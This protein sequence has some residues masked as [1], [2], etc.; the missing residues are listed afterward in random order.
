LR[1]AIIAPGSRGDV[2]P[3]LALGK[4]LTQAGHVVRLV[5]HQDF[6]MLVHAQGVEFWPVEGSVQAIV[7][8]ADMRALLEGGNFLAI[9]SQMAKEARNGA[10]RLARGGLA[11]CQGMDLVLAGIG[12]V[13]I[14][15]AL[16]EKLGLPLLQAYYIPF[17]PTRAFPSFILPKLPSWLGGIPNRFS[18]QLARQVM[19]QSFRSADGLAR[20]EVLGLPAAPFWGPFESDC[21]RNTPILYGYSPSVIPPPSDWDPAIHVTGYWF[22]QP[23]EE[24]TPPP[25][26][27][28]FLQAGSPPIYIGFGSM[29]NRRP[30]ETVDLILEALGRT[31][32][33][34]I[35]LSGWGG[36]Q[37]ADLPASVLMVDSIPFSWLFP[38]VAAVVHHGGAGTTAYGL[39]AGVP[40]IVIPFFG[41]QPY[42]GQR[43]AELGVGPEPIPRRKLT[44]ERLARAIQ[45]ALTDRSMRQRAGDLGK[46][47][48]AEDGIARAV[49]VVEQFY[50]HGD[51][52]APNSRLC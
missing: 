20:R 28:E 16:A 11:A 24:W 43:V 19:W 23:A 29:S 4:G 37:K 35:L 9:M 12:G 8:G 15:L 22:L 33:R 31:Q 50:E 47:I 21:V 7:Q 40:S 2:E 51:T 17:T 48:Q 18:Y 30:E 1:I 36:L 26:L 27:I 32:Q 25:A 52:L 41:D 39:R 42:W 34:A 46:K 6:E 38:R 14:G 3:Y 13:F 5:T 44:V 49:A 45:E 10:L